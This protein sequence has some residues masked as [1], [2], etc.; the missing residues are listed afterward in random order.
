MSRWY[1]DRKRVSPHQSPCPS[2]PSARIEPSGA[3]TAKKRP[4]LTMTRSITGSGSAR[5][6]DCLLGS[7]RSSRL[8]SRPRADRVAGPLAA[9]QQVHSHR[10]QFAHPLVGAD[11]LADRENPDRRVAFLDHVAG[12]LVKEDGHDVRAR[13]VLQVGDDA[14]KHG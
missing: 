14:A 2:G 8:E 11:R 4:S 6:T 3:E 10:F 12:F 5:G 9:R 1:S 13:G 7:P